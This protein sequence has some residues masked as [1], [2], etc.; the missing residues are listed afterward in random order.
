MEKDKEILTLQIELVDA[1][2]QYEI[3]TIRKE[4]NESRLRTVIIKGEP[5]FLGTDIGT[6]LGYVNPRKAYFDHTEKST[7]KPYFTSLVTIRNDLKRG[8][9]TTLRRRL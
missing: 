7:A 9:K 3:T 5:W 4:T 2:T 8:Q 6:C 1:K